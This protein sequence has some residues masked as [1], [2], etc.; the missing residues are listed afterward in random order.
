MAEPVEWLPDGTPR[1]P[2]FQD[3]YRSSTGGL[4]QARHVFLHGCGLPH[5][6]AG[7]PQWRILETGFGLGMNFLAA[8]RA[9]KDDPR[10]PRMLHFASVEAWPAGAAD[11][12]RSAAAHPELAPLAGALAAQW[13]GLVPGVHRLVFEDGRVLLT[14]LVADVQDALREPA[15]LADSVF[16]DGF[17]PERN[18]DMWRRHTLKAVARHCRVGTTLASWTVAGEVRRG[19]AE[20]G[21]QVA[22][23]DGLPPKRQCLRATFEPAWELKR[24]AAA[25]ATPAGRCIVVGAGLAGAA[26]AASLARRGWDVTVVDEA[27]APA[28]GASALPAGLLAPHQSSDDGLLARLSRS[29]VRITLQQATSML[30]AG[31]DW[32]PGGVLEH[33]IA[34]APRLPPHD[35]G[36]WRV[37]TRAADAAQKAAAGLDP[38]A[39]AT[40]HELAAWIT[41]AALVRAWLAQPGVAWCGQ[42]AVRELQPHG[43]GW[44][45]I[46]SDGEVL[47]DAGLVVLAAA[48]RTAALLPGALPLQPVRGQVSWGFQGASVQL[49]P[50]PVN[51]NGHFI[52]GVPV[53]RG[54]AWLC[55]STYDRADA[56]VEPRMQDHAANLGKLRLL[57]PLVADRLAPAFA[58][59]TVGAW[60]GVRCASAD[61]RPYV[62]EVQP[63]LW[64]STAM[65]SR[66]L[67]FA[68]LCGELLAARLHGEPLPLEPRLAAALDTARSLRP[69]M[70]GQ[71]EAVGLPPSQHQG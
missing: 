67:T 70:V 4:A 30:R 66:G 23:S 50:F 64:V 38:G 46:G 49:P 35:A 21:F 26:A 36:A 48:H 55:G 47:A 6:W 18:P 43:D 71:P 69:R 8:W 32:Q 56:D 29:G 52:P 7:Q 45:L 68:A 65:G 59:G 19:L 11:L 10:R 3:I 12:L 42:T 63:G 37:W 40:W 13:V 15:F 53:G 54:T 22:R 44:R 39:A 31:E 62:G 5:A 51:G 28:A 57:L 24:P 9:W 41:P 25:T 33:R 17:D 61:R 58:N 60:T 20:C 34:G 2:R 16:L 27:T 1:S 14:L